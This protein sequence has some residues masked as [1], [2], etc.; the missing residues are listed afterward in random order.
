MDDEEYYKK[1][2]KINRNN[3]YK[4]IN[5]NKSDKWKTSDIT[6]KLDEDKKT[7]IDDVSSD[8]K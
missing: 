5:K 6:E 8:Q 2:K 4:Q 7:K 3:L 1:I